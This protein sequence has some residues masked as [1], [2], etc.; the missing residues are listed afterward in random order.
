MSFKYK[1]KESPS[2]I[3]PTKLSEIAIICFEEDIAKEISNLP[4]I[5]VIYLKTPQ[6]IVSYNNGYCHEFDINNNIA[7]LYQNFKLLIILSEQ[8]PAIF[9]AY[10]HINIEANANKVKLLIEILAQTEIPTKLLKQTI[11]LKP[12]SISD[13]ELHDHI[14]II[15]GEEVP[16]KTSIPAIL[17]SKHLSKSYSLHLQPG[18]EIKYFGLKAESKTGNVMREEGAKFDVPIKKIPIFLLES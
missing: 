15:A 13:L 17:Q 14:A 6:T 7:K 12:I 10:Q 18:E 1:I 3:P 16:S 4:S 2:I 8:S 9:G 5:H 11:S